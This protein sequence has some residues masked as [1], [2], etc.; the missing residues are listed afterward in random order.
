MSWISSIYY[1]LP[2][3]C[4]KNIT[5]TTNPYFKGEVKFYVLEQRYNENVCV[6][7]YV[8]GSKPNINITTPYIKFID[9]GVFASKQ[10]YRSYM[11]FMEYF[12][13][14]EVNEELNDSYNLFLLLNIPNLINDERA[15]QSALKF[16]IKYAK[17]SERKY[18]IE[19]YITSLDSLTNKINFDIAEEFYYFVFK[20]VEHKKGVYDTAVSIFYRS[21]F[22]ILKEGQ[23]LKNII[24][25]YNKVAELNKDK[26]YF[27]TYVLDKTFFKFIEDFISL[28]RAKVL[29][30]YIAVFSALNSGL[31]FGQLKNIEGFKNTFDHGL[32]E[33]IME[34]ILEQTE[35]DLDFTLSFL[36]EALDLCQASSVNELYRIYSGGDFEIK[37]NIYKRLLAEDKK[38]IAFTMYLRGLEKS[39]DVIKY[40]DEY[41]REIL[42]YFME[43][44]KEYLGKIIIEYFRCLNREERFEEAKKLLFEY[45]LNASY[46]LN[47]DAATKIIESFELGITLENYLEYKDLIDKVRAIKIKNEIKTNIDMSFI[48]VI[49]VIDDFKYGDFKDLIEEI[50]YILKEYDIQTNIKHRNIILYKVGKHLTNLEYHK[51]MFDLFYDEDDLITYFEFVKINKNEENYKDILTS[52]IAYYL[53]YIEPKY[54]LLNKQDKNTEIEEAIINELTTFKKKDLEYFDAK[55]KEIFENLNLS[56]PIKWSI[57]LNNTKERMTLKYKII[58]LFKGK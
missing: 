27:Y 29:G 42:D 1:C 48:D 25:L 5:F 53:Y 38:E 13:Y 10:I 58:N 33:E 41:K 12:E 56:I 4:Y 22:N 51:E 21:I 11:N 44:S 26:P 30:L 45:V 31:S 9:T 23:S 37:R 7:D 24:D 34:Y 6:F 39:E 18:L 19:T 20:D 50:K 36:I 52:F 43:Y 49:Y 8:W 54:R 15:L 57:I 46:I 32:N 16:L 17:V 14:E 28:D 2:R 55:I 3:S 40:F 47:K 35:R